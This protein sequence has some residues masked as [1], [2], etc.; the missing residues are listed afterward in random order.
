MA[1]KIIVPGIKSRK[2]PNLKGQIASKSYCNIM[3]Y[4]QD[5]REVQV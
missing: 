3:Q 1:G 2:A 5:T 4:I